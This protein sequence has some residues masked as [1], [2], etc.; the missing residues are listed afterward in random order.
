MPKFT[1][2]PGPQLKEQIAG[3]CD[4]WK[5]VL[6]VL[7]HALT[8]NFILRTAY[9]IITLIILVVQFYITVSL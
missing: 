7:F 3:F 9:F 2:I 8:A 1:T 5:G 6:L 4:G